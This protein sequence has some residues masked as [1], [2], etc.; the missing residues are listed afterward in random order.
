MQSSEKGAVAKPLRA[1]TADQRSRICKLVPWLSR[2]LDRLDA[3]AALCMR[4]F[5]P[6]QPG[7]PA[8][9]G[10][11]SVVAHYQSMGDKARSIRDLAHDLANKMQSHDGWRLFIIA[12][13]VDRANPVPALLDPAQTRQLATRVEADMEMLARGFDIA[14]E[15]YKPSLR[16]RSKRSRGRSWFFGELVEAYLQG[17]PSEPPAEHLKRLLKLADI[18]QD[19]F[20]DPPPARGDTLLK[21]L[22]PILR[23]K[24]LESSDS[25]RGSPSH[26]PRG[27][28][29][30]T[31]PRNFPAS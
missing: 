17:A 22:R 9:M 12:Q 24:L 27:K 15:L 29:R 14:V 11:T 25:E 21:A 20:R 7:R 1:F 4:G 13:V 26:P 8:T 19:G 5:D 28:S 2:S 6:G 3:M 30:T 16:S 18:V 31:S 23:A 10:N